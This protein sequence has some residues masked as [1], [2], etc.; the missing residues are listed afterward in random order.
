MHTFFTVDVHLP[1]GGRLLAGL[2]CRCASLPTDPTSGEPAVL[3]LY[4]EV[5]DNKESIA[6]CT[7]ELRQFE[8]MYGIDSKGRT[9]GL[10]HAMDKKLRTTNERTD[11][12]MDG[13][14]RRSTDN[15]WRAIAGNFIDRDITA[16]GPGQG[17]D[18][19]Q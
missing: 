12:W 3:P 19:G 1:R 2:S 7:T 6:Q 16:S 14:C 11:R 10:L 4:T 13:C 18:E 15:Q 9:L 5:F 17:K 8:S